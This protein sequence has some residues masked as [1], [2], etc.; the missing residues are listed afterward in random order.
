VLELIRSG[1][2]VRGLQRAIGGG[3]GGGGG[4][5]EEATRAEPRHFV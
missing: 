2:S 1:M 3:H 4:M 5:A